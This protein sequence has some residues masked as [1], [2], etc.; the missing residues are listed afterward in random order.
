LHPAAPLL[1]NDNQLTKSR[2]SG[3]TSVEDI[4]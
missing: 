3:D 1:C 4:R 2:R